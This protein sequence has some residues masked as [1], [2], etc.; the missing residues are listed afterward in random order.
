MIKYASNT[1]M[2]TYFKY[3][4]IPQAESLLSNK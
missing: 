4:M 3:K 2:N 1:L